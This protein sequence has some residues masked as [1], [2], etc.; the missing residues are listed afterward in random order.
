MIARLHNLKKE[1]GIARWGEEYFA[2]AN[3]LLIRPLC[4]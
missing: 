3:S 1:G 4:S 2:A